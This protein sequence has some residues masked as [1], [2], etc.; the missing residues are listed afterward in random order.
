[1]LFSI[2]YKRLYKDKAIHINTAKNISAEERVCKNKLFVPRYA[3]VRPLSQSVHSTTGRE[4]QRHLAQ[5]RRY[6]TRVIQK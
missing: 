5:E 6:F 4:R 1:M 2:Y 3:A